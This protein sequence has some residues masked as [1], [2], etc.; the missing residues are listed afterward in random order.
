[1]AAG[2]AAAARGEGRVGGVVDWG[3]PGWANGS[4][5]KV[6]ITCASDTE[7]TNAVIRCVKGDDDGKVVPGG[8]L[9]FVWGRLRELEAVRGWWNGNRNHVEGVGAAAASGTS[10]G[11]DGGLSSA[12]ELRQ[13]VIKTISHLEAIHEALPPA[14]ALIVY[15][16]SGDPREMAKLNAVNQQFKREYKVKKWDELSVQW[17]DTEEQALK[18]A[19][20]E[21]RS[22]IGFLCVK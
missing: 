22:G 20:K 21:A 12:G 4:G 7:V 10:L 8:G 11:E 17:T 5:A 2:S 9:D 19:V 15:S 18:A 6:N 3:T 16:G 1:M 13:A 14:T